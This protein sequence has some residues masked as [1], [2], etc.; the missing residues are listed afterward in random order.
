VIIG[1]S[2]FTFATSVGFGVTSVPQMTVNSDSQITVVVPAGSGTVDVSVI[3]PVGTSATSP[4][5]Q[6]TYS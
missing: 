5:D 1:G 2:G 3:T 4:A 6:F